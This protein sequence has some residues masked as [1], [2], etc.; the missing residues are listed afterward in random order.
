MYTADDEARVF[1]ALLDYLRR[2]RGFDFTGYKRS[3]LKRRVQKRM[4]VRE[5]ENFSEYLDYLE[6]D[7]DEFTALFNTILINVTSFFRDPDAWSY[8]QEEVLA[9]LLAEKPQNETIRVWST[10]CA[11]GQEAYT[12]AIVLAELLGTEQFKQRVKIYATDV[13]EEALAQARQAKYT[14]KE[15]QPI[16]S[17]LHERYF[18]QV[19]DR[20]VF[21]SDLRR[22]IIFGRHDMVQD[23]PIPR[24]DLLVCR[25]A[26]MYFN[27]ETQARILARF[28]FALNEM[29]TLF[30]GK[31]EMLLAHTTLF[32]PIDL[33]HRIFR[34]V[35]RINTRDR[36]L[37]LSQGDD[38]ANIRLKEHIRLRE[39]AF[40]AVLI[41]QIILD[42]SGT[43]I[44]ANQSVRTLVVQR[45]F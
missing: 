11:S 1:E 15:L 6:A 27:A 2:V 21:R 24:L 33:Q 43:L 4:S 3:S 5:I 16:P 31:A 20:Y 32:L 14:A 30:L 26:L 44:L 42:V 38:E 12:L 41:P 7:P 25:N 45:T 17:N 36:L 35:L 8:L 39:V 22:V 34:K 9:P 13:D 18:E 40:D 37:F 19:G 23:A 28:H 10:G 29:G